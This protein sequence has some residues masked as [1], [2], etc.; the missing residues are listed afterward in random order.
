[1]ANK[2]TC[3][4]V[5]AGSGGLACGAILAKQ[6]LKTIVFEKELVVGGAAKTY[7]YRGYSIEEAMHFWVH[8]EGSVPQRDQIEKLTGLK[9]N[10]SK[11]GMRGGTTMLLTPQGELLPLQ[12]VS[13]ISADYDK[14]TM[15]R[16]YKYLKEEDVAEVERVSNIMMEDLGVQL[17]SVKIEVFD[18]LIRKLPYTP[19][20]G[21]LAEKTTNENVKIYIKDIAGATLLLPPESVETCSV[22]VVLILFL[23]LLSNMFAYVHPTFGNR[24][25]GYAAVM[26]PLAEV[27]KE[28]GGEVYTS[29][30]VKKIEI[31]NGAVK[32]VTVTRNGKD[33]FVPAD[34]VVCDVWPQWAYRSGIIDANS[35]P[36][37]YKEDFLNKVKKIQ[38]GARRY[39]VLTP[40]VNVGLKKKLTD[41]DSFVC[42]VDYNGHQVGG[43]E[44]LSN[45]SPNAAPP[46]HQLINS[47]SLLYQAPYD[48]SILERH[49]HEVVIPHLRNWLANF[50][51]NVEWAMSMWST[52]R[53]AEINQQFFADAPIFD[54]QTPIKNFYFTGMFT[55]YTGVEGAM[56]AGLLTAK[57]ILGLK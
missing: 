20:K 14:A 3:V 17:A 11:L 51:E 1:M 29:T 26:E 41:N 12:K 42:M 39:T 33:E 53:Y 23:A 56:Y 10:I 43:L 48:Y 45:L 40:V 7:D 6:G 24:Y 13:P 52:V 47:Q 28:S 9:W 27:I 5:G 34:I 2:K 30:P 18:D 15:L 37:P 25:G 46:G 22:Y 38:E 36:S 49:T 44:I 50:D 16:V 35:F 32:G 19:I 21:W 4:V 55:G 8:V 54:T 57:Q 31:Q